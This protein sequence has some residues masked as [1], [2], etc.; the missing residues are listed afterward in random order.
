MKKIATALAM[1][2]SF[3]LPSYSQAT[4]PR[5]GAV[6]H[7]GFSSL[8]PFNLGWTKSIPLVS[9]PSRGLTFNPRLTYNSFIWQK[10][11]AVWSPVVGEDGNP[12]WGWIKDGSSF[13]GGDLTYQVTRYR[14][15]ANDGSNQ[16]GYEYFGFKTSTQTLT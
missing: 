2:L 9:L 5:F 11:G 3:C 14:C 8:S 12:T 7:D 6:E 1:M 16:W 4:F 15:V 13:Q 10:N